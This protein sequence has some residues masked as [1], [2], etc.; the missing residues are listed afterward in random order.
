MRGKASD[1]GFSL[2]VDK[3]SGELKLINSQNGAVLFNARKSDTNINIGNSIMINGRHV[4][5][6]KEQPPLNAPIGS[7][8]IQTR[9]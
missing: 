3:T 2:S 9:V 5:I 6:Q 8:W 7:I 4:Y 1:R